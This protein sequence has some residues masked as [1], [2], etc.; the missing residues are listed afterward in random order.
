[1]FHYTRSWLN[2]REL[3]PFG[4]VLKSAVELAFR[5]VANVNY[6]QISVAEFATDH[7]IIIT[8]YLSLRVVFYA[9]DIFVQVFV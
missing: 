8:P 1:M 3:L 2:P 9:D 6:R 5:H 7:N 4:T